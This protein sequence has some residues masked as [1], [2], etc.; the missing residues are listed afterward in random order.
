MN[1]DEVKPSK[2]ADPTASKTD[3]YFKASPYTSLVSGDQSYFVANKASSYAPATETNFNNPF[4]VDNTKFLSVKI[5]STIGNQLNLISKYDHSLISEV[6]SPDARYITLGQVGNAVDLIGTNIEKVGS[7]AVNSGL[8]NSAPSY[9]FVNH[10]GATAIN[11]A[12]DSI[13]TSQRFTAEVLGNDTISPN[14]ASE[15]LAHVGRLY[16]FND[17]ALS[18]SGIA[19][20]LATGSDV[21]IE[22]IQE[23]VN[24]ILEDIEKLKSQKRNIDLTDAENEIAIM[25]DSI[26]EELGEKFHGAVKAIKNENEDYVAQSAA[27]LSSLLELLARSFGAKEQDELK[28]DEWIKKGLSEYLGV[29][30]NHYLVVQQPAFFNTL[31]GIRHGNTEIYPLYRDDKPRYKVFVLQIEGYIYS[32]ITFKNDK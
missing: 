19:N 7:I 15:T 31:A 11:I 21:K 32:L 17:S 18:M 1:T 14:L 16:A 13:A 28:K 22:K 8:I 30:K 12:T 2:D 25:L 26:D 10:P 6:A 20:S 4:G 29:D 9:D 3:I 24:Q 27:S 23:N 5:D